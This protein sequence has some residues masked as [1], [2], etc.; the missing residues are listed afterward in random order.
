MAS[1]IYNTLK[2]AVGDGFDWAAADVRLLLLDA[3]GSYTVDPTDQFV[4]D[5]TPGSNEL[6]TTNYARKVLANKAV[7]LNGNRAE[8]TAD[9]VTFNDLGGSPFPTVG[10][11]VLFVQVTNDADSWLIAYLE[12]VA[13]VTNGL[14][15]TIAF[16]PTGIVRVDQAA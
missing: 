15:A 14:D 10:G 12:D 8:W 11:A 7:A 2:E 5:L 9:N 6:S 3:A 1:T 16:D 4:A 13:G